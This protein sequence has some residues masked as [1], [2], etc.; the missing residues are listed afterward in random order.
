MCGCQRPG[1][2]HEA[3]AAKLDNYEIPFCKAPNRQRD[4]IYQEIFDSDLRTAP[5]MF[6]VCYAHQEA[7]VWGMPRTSSARTAPQG[8]IKITLKHGFI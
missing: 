2:L 8:G 4:V 6:L 7:A 3:A 1:R 5:S